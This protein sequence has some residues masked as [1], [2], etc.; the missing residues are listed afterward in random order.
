LFSLVSRC[1]PAC[2]FVCSLLANSA[3]ISR[4]AALRAKALSLPAAATLYGPSLTVNQPAAAAVGSSSSTSAVTGA[5]QLYDSVAEVELRLSG[6]VGI[7][8]RVCI[9]WH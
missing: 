8:V 1:I 5:G 7:E 3:L 4:Y 2:P 9:C 6:T